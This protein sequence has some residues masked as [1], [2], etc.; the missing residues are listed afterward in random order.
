MGMDSERTPSGLAHVA[1]V[2]FL[3]SRTTPSGG[4]W[5]ALA[6]GVAL[7]RAAARRGLRDGYGASSAA[8]LESVA[9]MG[10]IR[11]GVPLTQAITAPLLGRLEARAT[12][13]VRQFLVCAAL[14]I[15]H[16]TATT[17]FAIWVILGGLDAYAGTYDSIFDWLPFVPAGTA[18]A[19]ALTVIALLAW[20][21]FATTVQVL[22]YRRGLRRWPAPADEPEQREATELRKVEPRRRFDPRA[23]TVAGIVAFAVLLASTD[24]TVLAAVAAWLGVAWA[25]SRADPEPIPTGLVLAAILAG[26][27]LLFGVVGGVGTDVALRRAA[28]VALLVMVATWLRSAAGSAGMRLVFSQA[29]RRLRRIPS[30]HEAGRILDGLASERRLLEAGTAL[31]ASLGPVEKR[32]IPILDSV[33]GWVAAEARRFRAAPSPAPRPLSVRAYDAGLVALAAAPAALLFAG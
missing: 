1:T 14:R 2:S 11:F 12:S 16:N 6:G 9:I 30:M 26:S 24:W 28:R 25:V 23:V 5:L 31:A 21:I 8:M 7:A 17:A 33:L 4:F 13:F 20:A 10:P 32:P 19:L 18:G 27:A 22:V 15:L 3:A 29:L